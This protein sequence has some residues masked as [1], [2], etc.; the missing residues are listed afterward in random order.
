MDVPSYSA[1]FVEP[2]AQVLS[3]YECFSAE[4]L[5]ML[6]AIDP[7][8]RISATVASE[9]AVRQVEQ[10][11]DADLGLKA[12]RAMILGRA[13]ALD[14]TMHSAATVRQ[15]IDMARRYARL[16][17]DLLD[18]ST[19]VE[20]HRATIRID[21]GPAAPRPIP[22]FAM[23]AW[24]TNH[25]VEALHDVPRLE[26]WFSHAKPPETGEYERTFAPASLRFGAPCCGFAFAREYLDAPLPGADPVVHAVLRG[27]VES[28]LREL[29]EH[30]M[31]SDFADR[32]AWIANQELLQGTPTL[33][34]VAR[35]LRISP[36]SLA[37]WLEREETTFSA[38]LDRLRRSL[39]LRLAENHELGFAEIA[40]RLRFSHVEAFYRAFKR[41]TGQTPLGYRRR[42]G[43]GN[44]ASVSTSPGTPDLPPSSRSLVDAS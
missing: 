9:L 1:R 24:F 29:S 31:R 11:G 43:L 20:G 14:Y 21:V 34:G 37:R 36:R 8:T 38:I 25:L 27:H 23:S 5:D 19:V 4:S 16:F 39:G 28:A 40:T 13:G 18:V 3:T 22:D 42:C 30:A 10:T 41:W 12:G 7:A 2:F 33:I 26:C 17:S 35:Q 15:A 32:V 6:R 44:G